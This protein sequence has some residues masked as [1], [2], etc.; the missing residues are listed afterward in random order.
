MEIFYID[1]DLNKKTK[2]IVDFTNKNIKILIFIDTTKISI[3]IFDIGHI[4]P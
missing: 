1:L 3:S 4:I 2:I